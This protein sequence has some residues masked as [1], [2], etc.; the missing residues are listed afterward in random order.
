MRLKPVTRFSVGENNFRL[1]VSLGIRRALHV[2]VIDED[3][4]SAII[5]RVFPVS[6]APVMLSVNL[7]DALVHI[8]IDAAPPARSSTNR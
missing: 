4:D 5:T 1:H 7:D 8:E 6:A 2:S 3:R